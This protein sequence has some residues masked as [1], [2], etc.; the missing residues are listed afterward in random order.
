MSIKRN[1]EELK[2]I[3]KVRKFERVMLTHEKLGSSGVT[4]TSC[5]RDATE[6][7]SVRHVLVRSEKKVK[8]CNRKNEQIV[9]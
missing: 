4:L 6:I 5:G 2:K 8:L 1:I 7:S 9:W 3:N